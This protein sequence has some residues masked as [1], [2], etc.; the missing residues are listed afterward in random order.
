M[1]KMVISASLRSP[2]SSKAIGPVAPLYVIFCSS[3]RYFFGSLESAYFI[4][5]ISMLAAS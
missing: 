2:L 4:A 5:S 1:V 3:G